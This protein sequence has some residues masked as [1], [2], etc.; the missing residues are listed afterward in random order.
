MVASD[1][2]KG[3]VAAPHSVRPRPPGG[4]YQFNCLDVRIR[5]RNLHRGVTRN[6]LAGR[7]LALATTRK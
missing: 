6:E 7:K 1:I 4:N 2:E 3:D 5:V